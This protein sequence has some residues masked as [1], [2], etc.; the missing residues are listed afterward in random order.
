VWER[1]VWKYCK[2]E[3][4]VAIKWIRQEFESNKPIAGRIDMDFRSTVS[5]NIHEIT[6]KVISKL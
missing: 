3:D 2:T 6:Y 4:Q 1:T 5:D